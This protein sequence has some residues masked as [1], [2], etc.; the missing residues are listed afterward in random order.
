MP[1]SMVKKYPSSIKE[2]YHQKVASDSAIYTT[3]LRTLD[4]SPMFAE[5]IW[6]QLSAFDLSELGLGLLYSILPADFKPYNIAFEYKS[7]TTEET[8]QGIWA[9][10]EPVDLSQFYTWMADF[11]SYVL[12]N[13]KVEYQADLLLK[14]MKKAIYG[15]TPYG[16]GV[17]DPVVAREFLR[18]GFYKLRLLRTPDVSWKNMMDQIADYLEMVGVTDEH[19]FNRLMMIFSAQTESFVLG[20]SLLG[21]SKLSRKEGDLAVIP[22]MDAKGNIYDLKFSTLD[23]LQ[24]G[25]ILGVTPLGYGLLL[26]KKSIYNLPEGYKNPPVIKAMI[27]KINKIK[28]TITLTTWAY[29]NY[30]KPEEM[31]NYHR[32]DKA[33]QYDLLQTQRRHIEN[34][35]FNQVP[36]EESNPVRIRQYQNAVLQLISWKAKR[37]AWGFEGWETMTED[38]FHTWWINYWKSQGLNENTLEKLYSIIEPI[39]DDLRQNKIMLGE[40][41]KRSRLRLALSF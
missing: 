35:V 29:S 25:F 41:I 33:D 7:P 39:L 14:V 8:M 22:F 19:I 9:K 37:H 34:I 21:R 24:M 27:D 20:L 40:K 26:P 31:I 10:F 28:N 4:V 23:H 1:K 16:R 15:I 5:Y 11:K 32:S 13:I 12:D 30:N 6:L 38:Q 17:Y 2:K 18:S 36:P 3:Y